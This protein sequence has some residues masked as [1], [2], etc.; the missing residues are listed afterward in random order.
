MK[1]RDFIKSGI[2]AVTAG[3]FQLFQMMVLASLGQMF[4]AGKAAGADATPSNYLLFLHP[5][6]PPRWTTDGFLSPNIPVIDGTENADFIPHSVVRNCAKNAGTY[7][8][9]YTNSNASTTYETTTTSYQFKDRTGTIKEIYMPKIW[10][11]TLPEWNGTGVDIGSLR[12]SDKLSEMM[13]IRGYQLQADFGHV[14]GPAL[15][16][17]PIS[18]APSI[19]GLVADNA[20][21]V[22]LIPAVALTD[23]PSRPLGF[24]SLGASVTLGTSSG[25]SNLANDILQSFMRSNIGLNHASNKQ[26]M[27]A[28]VDAALDIYK[29]EAAKL[30]P[31]ANDIYANVKAVNLVVEKLK[32]SNLGADYTVLQ[33]KYRALVA[34]CTTAHPGLVGNLKQ[35]INGSGVITGVP[36]MVDSYSDKFALAELFINNGLTASFTFVCGG[37]AVPGSYVGYSNNPY[38][39][40]NDEHTVTDRMIS[41]FAHNWKYRAWMACVHQFSIA[42]GPEK[43]SRTVV[44]NGAEYA[45][46]PNKG[47]G[48]SDHAINA[49]VTSVVSGTISSFMPIGN[50]YKSAV[51]DPLHNNYGTYGVGAATNIEGVGPVKIPNEYV[52]NSVMALLGIS[53]PFRDK[54]TLIKSVAGAWLPKTED[55]KNV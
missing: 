23:S 18:S 22:N 41:L 24:R 49:C 35:T 9:D 38:G 36:Y 44:Q 34:Y 21:S 16:S 26:I 29:A 46:A 2:G 1:R 32:S 40:Q 30:D 33:S 6:A 7:L 4:R 42:I 13:I 28:A 11:I 47:S 53:S 17:Q 51:T 43:W 12:M 20:S 3:Q 37:T 31:K 8:T 52:A 39:A 15:Q 54:T 14:K 25:T 55:P 19:S 48:G 45:R 27:N 5:G 50:I 10:E